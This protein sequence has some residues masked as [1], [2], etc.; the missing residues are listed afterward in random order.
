M[1]NTRDLS[2]E[3][4][5]R[6]TLKLNELE[7]SA[8]VISFLAHYTDSLFEWNPKINLTAH[9]R[10]EF[11][12]QDLVDALFLAK[13][14]TQSLS[15]PSAFADFSLDTN[16]MTILDMGCGNGHLGLVL[17]FLFPSFSISFLDASRKRINFVRHVCREMGLKGGTFLNQRTE[18]G[19]QG[20]P[21]NLVI[22]RAT[23]SPMT[24]FKNARNYVQNNGYALSLCSSKQKW[25]EDDKFYKDFKVV[26]D[27]EYTILPTSHQR[28]LLV[29][30]KIQKSSS[31]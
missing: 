19:L 22:S 27:H 16:Q 7:L 18:E 29:V 28:R 11:I 15:T 4:T 3:E 9:T 12:N 10:Q 25:E 8:D 31:M 24:F 20:Q 26:I 14:L 6:A 30:K 2:T 1:R 5:L 23:W 17:Q 13:F 21:F